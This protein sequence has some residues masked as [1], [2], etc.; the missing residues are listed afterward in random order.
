MPIESHAEERDTPTVKWPPTK[1][2]Q[3]ENYIYI[4]T[5]QG[6]EYRLKYKQATF[7]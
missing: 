2:I 6:N 4:S 1:K 5:N 3:T 7:T